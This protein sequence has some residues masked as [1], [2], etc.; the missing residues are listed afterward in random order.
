MLGKD[1]HAQILDFISQGEQN[2][3]L[4]L[5]IY[6]FVKWHA[7]GEGGEIVFYEVDRIGWPKGNLNSNLIRWIAARVGFELSACT[8]MQNF[9]IIF[10]AENSIVISGK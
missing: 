7:V 2:P 9:D 1:Y 3:F 4:D 5:K 10:F 8:L 6:R